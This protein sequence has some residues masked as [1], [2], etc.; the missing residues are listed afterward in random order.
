M[1]SGLKVVHSHK[2]PSSQVVL[3][4]SS[5]LS[6]R[7]F[8]ALDGSNPRTLTGHTAAV[9]DAVMVARGRHIVTSSNDGTVRL[10]SVSDSKNIKTWSKLA[11]DGPLQVRRRVTKLA[12]LSTT[13]SSEGH[14]GS[15]AQPSSQGMEDAAFTGRHAVVAGLEDGT[16]SVIDLSATSSSPPLINAQAGSSRRA[17]SALSS[18]RTTTTKSDD[19]FVIAAGTVDGEVVVYTCSTA[20]SDLS[21]LCRFKRNSADITALAFPQDSSQRKDTLITILVA[22]SDG[23]PYLASIDAASGKVDI[24]AEYAGFNID[25]AD[26]AIHSHDSVFI[27][28]KDGSLKR[29]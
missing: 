25:S 11:Q 20:F 17:V 23:L 3:S 1:L 12:I 27:A 28:G 18:R 15:S 5:D 6:I 21:E 29:Y 14:A 8:S 7:I 10:W 2:F 24:S 16:I 4:T 9:T 19:T 26:S 13:W 22:T